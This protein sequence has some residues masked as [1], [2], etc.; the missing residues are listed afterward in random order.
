MRRRSRGS[1]FFKDK[2]Y[3]TDYE[4]H[5]GAALTKRVI[6]GGSV[7]SRD[8]PVNAARSGSGDAAFRTSPSPISN[9]RGTIRAREFVRDVIFLSLSLSRARALLCVLI[10]PIA[11]GLIIA[12]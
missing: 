2:D 12:R 10:D 6:A 1:R 9:R 8:F 5:R 4:L 11:R 3:R 7:I